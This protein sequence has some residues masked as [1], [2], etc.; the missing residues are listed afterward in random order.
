M[1]NAK[2][3]LI[4]SLNP[5]NLKL[6]EPLSKHSTVRIGGP[7]EIWYEPQTTEEFCNAIK[8][9][10]ELGI[11]ITIL[12]RGS[13]TLISDKGIA[14]LIIRN[15]SKEIKILEGEIEKEEPLKET[16]DEIEARWQ[17]DNQKGTFK[18]EFK[19]LDYDENNLPRIEVSLESGVDM[20]FAINYLIDKG[21]TGLQWY[22]RIPGNL[23]GWIYNNVHGGT[24]FINEVVKSVK[25]L[26]KTSNIQIL[27]GSEL[28]FEY[29]KSRFQTSGE[30]ILEA[31]LLLYKGDKEKA[32]Y[33]AMEWAKRKS[34]QPPNSLGSIFK[35]ID[36]QTKERLGYPTTATGYIVEHVLKMSGFKIN[37]AA[38]SP[39]HHN[40]IENTGNASAK[41]YLEVIKTII[42]RA[43]DQI[44]INLKPEIF[45]LGFTSQ[46]LSF[47]K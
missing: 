7:A 37:D 4:K 39:K 40:F 18:Y 29:D 20:P 33:V 47:L 31:N 11:S 1:D 34:I 23:G 42:D 15:A 45:F 35:N 24:H 9:A 5:S 38:I 41:D 14:G 22:S 2:E 21:I 32:K 30:I 13:N 16:I 44:G 43:K 3:K 17:S 19:D 36:N 25:V 6:N 8:S 27:S 28:A 10:R 26:D 12:G 46:E